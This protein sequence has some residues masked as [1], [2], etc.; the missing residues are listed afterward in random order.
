[1]KG[2]IGYRLS[3]IGLLL[4]GSLTA[5]QVPPLPDSTGWGVR[6]LALAQAPDSSIWVG[7]YGQGIFVLRSGASIWEHIA[8]LGDT[9]AHSMSWDFVHAFG[10]GAHGEIWYGTVGN[11]WGVST[12]DGKTWKNWEYRQLGPEWQYVAPN[13][14]VT[15]G[16]P[17]VGFKG[18]ASP[19]NQDLRARE[20]GAAGDSVFIH[21]DLWPA[22]PLRSVVS[23]AL[24]H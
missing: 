4:G 22:E 7:T 11:G 18:T 8:H 12:D 1:M 17:G 23:R 19:A 21:R 14:I 24:R 9:S 15:R 2:A 20:A 16:R 6:V 3:A 13:G 10:F 5:Q